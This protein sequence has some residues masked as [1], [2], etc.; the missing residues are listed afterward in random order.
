MTT[1]HSLMSALDERAIANIVGI[2]HDE[3]RI[4]YRLGSNTVRDFPE[5]KD[6]ITDYYNYHYTTCVSR[7][8]SLTFSEAYGRA[9]E[10]LEREYRRRDGDIVSAFN[11]AHDGTNGGM[12]LVLDTIADGLKAEVIE[13]YMTEIFDRYVAPN[14]WEDKV[15]IIRQ[16]ISYCGGML[17]SSIVTAQPERYAHDYSALIR[18][19]IEGLRKTS[20]MF[21]RM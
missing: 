11:D 5:F 14:S 4:R 12:R 10:L 2:A 13:R 8:G 20:S 1:I 7:G 9:K 15:E 17:A 18:A 6:V 19:Y 3:A 21:R 16:F